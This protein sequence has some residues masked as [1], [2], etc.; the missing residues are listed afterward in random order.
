M[1]DP[2]VVDG[3]SL[4][5]RAIMGSVH[6][7]LR[8]HLPFRGGV[9]GGLNTLRYVLDRPEVN[10]GGAYVCF[11]HAPPPRRKRLIP[12]YKAHK[13][14]LTKTV[15]PFESVEQK[16]EVM[17]QL[18]TAWEL[19]ELIGCT[20]LRYK[21]REGDDTVGGV[22]RVMLDK[23]KRPLVVTSD[24]DLWQVVHWGAHVWDLRRDERIH[25]VNF[26][27]RAGVSTDCYLL[28]RALVGGKDGIKGA[29]GIGPDRARDLLERAH[30]HIRLARDPL[31][32]LD[33]LCEYIGRRPRSTKAETR[34]VA[35][36]ARLADTIRGTDLSRSFGPLDGLRECLRRR[37][38]PDERAFL[39][40]CRDLGFRRVMRNPRRFTVPFAGKRR[41][42]RRKRP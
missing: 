34:L 4:V 22:V 18:W 36:R 12:G 16:Q 23:G 40:R 3:N 6:E 24:S 27:L 11:D 30:W 32:Q 37:P 29:I 15:E 5:M 35:D 26:T 2:V 20:C 42:V 13:D 17:N 39:R 9:Y 31:A 19:F 28:Y 33:A 38:E 1:A 41:R 10:A 7:E 25:R 8:L 21:N 14:D